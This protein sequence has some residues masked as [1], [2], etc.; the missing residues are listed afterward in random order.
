MNIAPRLRRPHVLNIF[1]AA[2][3]A[4]LDDLLPA[5]DAAK[6]GILGELH[7]FAACSVDVGESDKVRRNLRLGIVAAELAFEVHPR[8]TEGAHPIGR[9][10]IDVTRKYTKER[11]ARSRRRRSRCDGSI[12]VT[13]ARSSQRSRGWIASR[14][15]IQMDSM[16]VLRASS[17]PWR[18]RMTPRGAGVP[19]VRTCRAAASFC[20]K[21]PCP[22]CRYPARPSNPAAARTSAAITSRGRHALAGGPAGRSSASTPVPGRFHRAIRIAISTRCPR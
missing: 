15:S 10:R 4:I 2:P 16:A 12:P 7:S 9:P 18:S 3:Q 20:R 14:G 6:R 8:K 11:S 13:T 5:R 21:S 1:D 22:I 19:T 17:V